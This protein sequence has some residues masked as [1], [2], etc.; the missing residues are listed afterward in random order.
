M[1]FLE[2]EYNGREPGNSLGWVIL[3]GGQT[4]DHTK[5]GKRRAG[6]GKGGGCVVI[7]RWGV[8]LSDLR[9]RWSGVL[10]Y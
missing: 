5:D 9:E 8:P 3:G 2:G 6:Y 7:P 1:L 10:G 4:E